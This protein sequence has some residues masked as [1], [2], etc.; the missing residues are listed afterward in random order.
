ME[1]QIRKFFKVEGS[2]QK[3]WRK[4]GRV[5]VAITENEDWWA[6]KCIPRDYYYDYAAE[7]ASNIECDCADYGVYVFW[8]TPGKNASGSR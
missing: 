7:K 2:I 6:N 4:E 1:E 5:Y 8:E 3:M